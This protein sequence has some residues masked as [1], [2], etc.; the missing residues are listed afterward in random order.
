MTAPALHYGGVAFVVDSLLRLEDG[1]GGF[2]RSTNDD[3]FAV[4][5]AALDSA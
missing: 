5:D 4:A 1:R 3:I 2:E